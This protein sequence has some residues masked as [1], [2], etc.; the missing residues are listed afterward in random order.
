MQGGTSKKSIGA[1]CGQQLLEAVLA[2]HEA[3]A[4]SPI[5]QA[6]PPLLVRLQ[7]A[8]SCSDADKRWQ[9]WWLVVG[10]HSCLKTPEESS[11]DLNHVLMTCRHCMHLGLQSQS[12]ACLQ[13]TPH[14]LFALLRP[15]SRCSSL[16]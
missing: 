15:I 14:S 2:A 10:I 16:V 12:C 8:T 6:F 5:L 7:C 13:R 9:C 11:S 1:Q 3:A 4:E